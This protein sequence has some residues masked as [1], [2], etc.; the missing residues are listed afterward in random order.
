MMKGLEI[1]D[2]DD[3]DEVDEEAIVDSIVDM[4]RKL[5]SKL[6]NN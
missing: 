6:A 1:N 5:G 4:A 2:D 3:G